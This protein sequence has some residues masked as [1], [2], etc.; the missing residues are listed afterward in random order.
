MSK[1]FTDVNVFMRAA[2]QNIPP[3]NANESDQSEQIGRAH[4]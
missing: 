2:G 1:T 4:V 3:F